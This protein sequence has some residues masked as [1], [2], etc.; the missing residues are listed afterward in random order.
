MARM[1]RKQICIDERLDKDLERL[2]RSQGVSQS[3]IVREA[4]DRLV[5]ADASVATSSQLRVLDAM[6]ERAD[7]GPL[8]GGRAW[9]RESLHEH[10][11]SR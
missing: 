5:H 1:V 6:R 8:A 2:A 10:D 3:R 7:A 9:T 4:L 11:V